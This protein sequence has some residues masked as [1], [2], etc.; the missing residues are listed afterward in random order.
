M[1]KN[2]SAKDNS[3]ICK[4]SDI[5]KV[6]KINFNLNKENANGADGLPGRFY[7]SCRKIIDSDIL[8]MIQDFF[9]GNT[10]LESITHTNLIL[11]QKKEHIQTFSD[12]RPTSLSSF[13]NKILPRI[14]ALLLNLIYNHQSGYYILSL[15]LEMNQSLGNARL[16][17]QS[18]IGL[19]GN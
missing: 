13:I 5:E 10:L 2:I 14:E 16:P 11:L 9:G 7:Q 12:M 15:R 19:L 3:C 6:R 1:P 8:K 4:H 18:M 17:F